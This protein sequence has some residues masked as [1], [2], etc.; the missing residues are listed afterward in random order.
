METP[1]L[2]WH[3]RSIMPWLPFSSWNML[4]DGGTRDMLPEREKEKLKTC[5]PAE[6][7]VNYAKTSLSLRNLCSLRWTCGLVREEVGVEHLEPFVYGTY[8]KDSLPSSAMTIIPGRP[9][10]RLKSR[11]T[12]PAISSVAGVNTALLGIILRS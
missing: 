11:I 7:F 9:N 10:G 6:M 5:L 2:Y 1:T 8:S 3:L 12:W 4:T